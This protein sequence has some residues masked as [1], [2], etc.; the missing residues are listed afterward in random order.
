MFKNKKADEKLLSPWMF[1]IWIVVI[2]GVTIGAS[3]VYGVSFNIKGQESKV[4]NAR[5]MDCLVKDSNIRDDFFISNFDFYKEC[6]FQKSILEDS[7]LF[8][9][10][11]DVTNFSSYT[12]LYNFSVGNK[13][14]EFQWSLTEKS[15]DFAK[16][17]E[18]RIKTKYKGEV[19]LLDVLT[20]SNNKG[21]KI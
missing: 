4:L 5:V 7:N 21:E 6:N 13:D 8:F 1:L 12:T 11:V 15:P 3:M 2:F 18:D 17:F 20:C 10:Y 14:L 16:C 19:I 9:I